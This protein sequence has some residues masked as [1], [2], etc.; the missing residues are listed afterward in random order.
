MAGSPLRGPSGCFRR[1]LA[2]LPLAAVIAATAALAQ[3]EPRPLLDLVKECDVLAA[4]PDDPQRMAEGVADDKIV[5]RLAVLACEQALKQD[6][7]DARH[8]FQL[9]RALL[10]AGREK[11]ALDRFQQAAQ[12]GHAAA[13]GYVGDAHL[14]GRGVTKNADLARKHY[15][16]SAKAGFQRSK[17][18][19]ETLRFDASL[20]LRPL[21]TGIFQ[22]ISELTDSLNIR[23]SPNVAGYVFSL[24]MVINSE[25]R[26][27]LRPSVLNH[28]LELRYN[29]RAVT[30]EVESSA[31]YQV[32][33]AAG[34]YDGQTFVRRHGCEGPVALQM[35]DNLG[36]YISLNRS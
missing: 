36:R 7:Q 21:I 24:T 35:F 9:G 29:S 10:A 13:A 5:P 28:F 18:M 31:S 30:P 8:A 11:D 20:Y 33:T 12:A 19:L 32:D 27:V 4:H 15:D 25:C 6:G 3:Q 34:D 26:G 22:G 2:S 16:D 23:K 17:A 14:F 1:A